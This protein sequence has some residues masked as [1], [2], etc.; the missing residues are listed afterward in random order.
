METAGR[1]R[2][3]ADG[4][5]DKNRIGWVGRTPGRAAGCL[6]GTAWVCSHLCWS[7]RDSRLHQHQ[8]YQ[9]MK[10]RWKPS[11]SED[12]RIKHAEIN[13]DRAA[14]G[15]LVCVEELHFLIYL[16]GKQTQLQKTRIKAK[17]LTMNN[18]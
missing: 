14:N 12:Q 10:H 4:A 16:S 1:E 3:H 2:E 6:P 15:S 8:R 5:R 13:L 7:A 11:A 9:T 18:D 17:A